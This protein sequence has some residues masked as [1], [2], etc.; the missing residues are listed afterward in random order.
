M[1][2]KRQRG[3]VSREL[4][5]A[6]RTLAVMR[7]QLSAIHS[8]SYVLQ[9][10][11]GELIVKDWKDDGEEKLGVLLFELQLR[12]CGLSDQL[13]HITN[14]SR[15][16]A[17]MPSVQPSPV[18]EAHWSLFKEIVRD[19]R[20]ELAANS[21]TLWRLVIAGGGTCPHCATQAWRNRDKPP[22]LRGGS[23]GD[24]RV[25]ENVPFAVRYILDS[26][27]INPNFCPV[28]SQ[29]EQGGLGVPVI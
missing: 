15:R 13:L 24:E 12:L 11:C 22:H 20:E 17:D 6:I 14:E 18:S 21:Q 8:R 28:I 10:N 1:A 27:P 26:N 23:C 5:D 29:H 3:T 25:P 4:A 2:S 16:L 19:V 9:Q 7:G